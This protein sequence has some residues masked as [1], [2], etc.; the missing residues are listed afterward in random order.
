MGG[1]GSVDVVFDSP[2]LD[3]HVGFE[4]VVEVAAIEELVVEAELRPS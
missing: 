1:V 3:E 4:E 2:L